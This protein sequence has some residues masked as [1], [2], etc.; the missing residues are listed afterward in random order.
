MNVV[1]YLKGI[2]ASNK[3]PEKPEVLKRFVQ[4]VNNSGTGDTGTQYEGLNWTPSDVAVLQGYVHEDSPMTP[5]L[6]LRK[7]VLD[8]QKIN[9]KRTVIIDSN[10]F[11]YRDLGNTN[12]YLRYSYD[13]V[14]PST[15]EYCWN[16]P[17]P[18]RWKKISKDLKINLQEW[19]QTGN[20]IL[21]CM[22]R[23]GGWSMKGNNV[24]DWLERTIWKIRQHSDRPIIVRG[25][26]GDRKTKMI[27]KQ[28]RYPTGLQ[29]LNNVYFSDIERKTLLDDLKT[30]WATVVYNS[31]P[32]VA[33][34]IEGVPVFCEDV[35]DCQAGEV[36]N[37]DL[38]LVES[39]KTFER[40][41]WIEKLAMCHWNWDDLSNGTAWKHMREYV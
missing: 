38:S 2:P 26:P 25:H 36:C 28:K 34:A 5:H 6:R 1:S 40:Q 9:N 30:A 32:S 3:N 10:L 13:G 16:H 24:W 22:Q 23:N 4:G 41:Q 39:P 19:K 27:I 12:R 29:N 35:I 8:K 31:S 20:H 17:N 37:T 33:S 7:E 18:N 14:F 15:A 11:L 21:I